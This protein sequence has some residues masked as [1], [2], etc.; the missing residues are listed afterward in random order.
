MF[1]EYKQKYLA[2]DVCPLVY[3]CDKGKPSLKQ[4]VG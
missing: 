1:V 2:K 4:G 3:N